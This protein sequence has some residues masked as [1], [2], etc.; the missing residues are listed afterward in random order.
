M[1]SP[2]CRMQ[3]CWQCPRLVAASRYFK[4]DQWDRT[5]ALGVDALL[6]AM[7]RDAAPKEGPVKRKR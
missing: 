4:P 1:L 7:L 5:F 3:L 6:Q 2:V